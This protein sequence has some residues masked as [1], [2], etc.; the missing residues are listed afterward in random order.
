MKNILV[1]TGGAGFVGSNLI[2]F[3][4]IKT[5]FDIISVDN[6]SSGSRLNHV[7]SKR[8]KYIK[9]NTKFISSVL[10]KYEKKY[11]LCFTLENL[12]EFFKVLKNLMNVL[13]PTL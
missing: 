10:K 6:Y 8:I 5:K 2:K 1:V 7:K 11:T 9:S 4:L 12:Q 3:L 13:I